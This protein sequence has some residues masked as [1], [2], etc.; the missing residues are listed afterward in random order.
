MSY[1]LA[2][3]NGEI[4]TPRGRYR[5]SLGIEGGRIAAIADTPVEASEVVDA[6]GLLVLPG[7][8]DSHVHFRDPAYPEKED[9]LTGTAAAARGGVTTVFE[10]PT[11][12]VAVTTRERFRRRR[13]ILEPKAIVDFGMYGGAGTNPDDLA[14]LAEEGAIAFKTFMCPPMPGREQNWAGVYALTSPELYTI[15]RAVA[16]TGRLGCVHAE[17]RLLV[18]AL[19]AE[20]TAAALGPIDAYLATHPRVVEIDPVQRAIR[21]ARE[22]GMRLHI[23]HI[24]SREA[25]ELVLRARAAGQPVS[26]EVVPLYLFFAREDLPELGPLGRLVPSIQSA[27]DR[28]ALWGY[29]ARGDVDTVSSDHAAMSREDIEAGWSGRGVPHAGYASIE[30]DSLLMLTEAQRGRLSLERLV[31]VMS[32]NPAR[33]YGLYPRKGAIRVGADA[34]LTLVDPDRHAVIRGAEM[35]SKV[36]FTVY[37][38][39]EVHGLPVYTFVRGTCVMRDGAVIGRPGHG[40]LVRPA[41]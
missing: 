29:L 20:A 12:D 10:M 24:T 30:H 41:G 11:S 21:Y 40:Q 33:L 37:E 19:Q 26:V 7:L 2:I 9:F 27:A 15:F 16:A 39:W 31:A 3:Q 13:A 4:V 23:V 1:D 34:D 18:Q 36:K 8:I 35:Q 14:D 6:S 22:V 32:E 28:E 5:A 38:G 25:V 17:D